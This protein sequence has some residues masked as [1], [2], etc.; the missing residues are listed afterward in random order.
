MIISIAAR[1]GDWK[2]KGGHSMSKHTM[3]N[4]NTRGG[5]GERT[6]WQTG[7]T[8]G[9]TWSR[10]GA[11]GYIHSVCIVFKLNPVSKERI[12]SLAWHYCAKS[13][14][15]GAQKLIHIL[16]G[17]ATGESSSCQANDLVIKRWRCKYTYYS[18]EMRL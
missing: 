9:M 7:G 8:R 5:M 1:R 17:V 13:E 12:S 11:R 18:A 10:A 15:S 6:S 16:V 2:T 4:T 14:R 3:W